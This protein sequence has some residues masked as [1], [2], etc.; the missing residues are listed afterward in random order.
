MSEEANKDVVRSFVEAWEEY[1]EA[2]M[3]RQLGQ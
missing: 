2:G 1:D 3:R